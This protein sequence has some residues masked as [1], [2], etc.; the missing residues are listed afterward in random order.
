MQ[1]QAHI[2][3][4]LDEEID[5]LAALESKHKYYQLSLFESERKK[6]EQER[7]VDELFDKFT[8]WVTDTLTIQNN[9]YIRIAAVMKG[10]A[11]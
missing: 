8:N 6:S 2:N 7:K 4:L 11:R 5:K 9:P 3:P 1:Y 10:V